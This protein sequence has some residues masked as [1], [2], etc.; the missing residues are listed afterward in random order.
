MTDQ[1]KI[2]ELIRKYDGFWMG[3]SDVEI[4]IGEILQEAITWARSQSQAEI[5]KLLE[6][7]GDL[8]RENEA[9]KK[10][11]QELAD[12]VK[13]VCDENEE[14]KKKIMDRYNEDEES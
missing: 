11:N 1:E 4:S 12:Y 14:L 9:L 13:Q 7:S 3:E 2:E 10:E 5:N 8:L 6:D